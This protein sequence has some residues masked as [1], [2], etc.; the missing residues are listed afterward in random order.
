MNNH[1]FWQ[2]ST[3]KLY[4]GRY[5]L[6]NLTDIAVLNVADIQKV[7]GIGGRQAYDLV[8]S[9]QFRVIRIGRTIKIPKDSF[10]SW[11]NGESA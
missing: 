6:M 9:E 11:L 2:H 1:N 7:L 10:I 3:T 5:E 4:P 8:N